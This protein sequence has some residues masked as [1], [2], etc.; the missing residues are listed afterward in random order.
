MNALKHLYP[1]IEPFETFE[2][3]VGDGHT[4]Y[5]EQCGAKDGLPVIVLHGG[6]GG[7]KGQMVPTR[8][9]FRHESRP[10]IGEGRA[11]PG[12]DSPSVPRPGLSPGR[13]PRT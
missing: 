10:E 2:L 12:V 4:L 8:R 9:L 13:P 6:P 11:R 5:V 3:S 7:G 1:P